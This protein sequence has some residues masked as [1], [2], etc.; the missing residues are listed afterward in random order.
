MARDGK[1]RDRDAH[2][3]RPKRDVK[4]LRR[5]RDESETFVALET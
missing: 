1:A 4:I 2:L 5:D 3:P